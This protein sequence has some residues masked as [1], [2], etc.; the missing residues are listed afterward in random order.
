[1]RIILCTKIL[2]HENN[3]FIDNNDSKVKKEPFLKIVN[4]KFEKI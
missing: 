1:M 2:F 3:S 4:I